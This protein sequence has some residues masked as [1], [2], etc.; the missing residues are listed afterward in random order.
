MSLMTASFAALVTALALV[1][2]LSTAYPTKDDEAY[3][4]NRLHDLPD[5][6]NKDVRNLDGIDS[7]EEVQPLLALLA[8]VD[9]DASSERG[10]GNL[11]RDLDVLRN[12]AAF[13]S[14]GSR[15][16]RN[17]RFD[18]LMGSTLGGVK[19]TAGGCCDSL[20]GIGLGGQKRNM[21][22]IDRTGFNSFI[23]K[24]FDEIDRS[25]FG[26]FVKRNFD[27]IDR[28][29]FGG[30]VKRSASPAAAEQVHN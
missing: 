3:Y 19:R 9:Q 26:S 2:A 22:E 30:F 14:R 20:S 1:L 10:G 28:S 23:K 4:Y 24:N 11:L 13:F 18:T 16:P 12:R 15:D 27:E 8:K 7:R 29:G 25:G 5:T 6:Y 21:D 17:Y